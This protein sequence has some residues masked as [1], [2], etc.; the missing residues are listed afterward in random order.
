MATNAVS[1]PPADAFNPM[2][3]KE[4]AGFPFPGAAVA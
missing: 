2:N 3:L 1:A 4:L